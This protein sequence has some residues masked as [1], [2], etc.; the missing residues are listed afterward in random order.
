LRLNPHEI[1]I[2]VVHLGFEKQGNPSQTVRVGNEQVSKTLNF[3]QTPIFALKCT[4]APK[5]KSKS[6]NK[7]Y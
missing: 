5:E 7:L 2:G 6:K 4:Q 1:L 3:F